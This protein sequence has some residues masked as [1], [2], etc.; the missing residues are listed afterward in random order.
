MKNKGV[1][2]PFGAPVKVTVGEGLFLQATD[3]GFELRPVKR[4]TENVRMR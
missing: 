1:P 3:I 2:H 4:I